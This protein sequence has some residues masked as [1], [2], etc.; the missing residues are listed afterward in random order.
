VLTN[1]LKCNAR[2]SSAYAGF[3]VV[4]VVVIGHSNGD[5]KDYLA[6]LLLTA[7]VSPSFLAS[8][9]ARVGWTMS[10]AMVSRMM[11]KQDSAKRGE[12]GEVL[13][14]GVL[15]EHQGYIM[16]VSKLRGKVTGGQS[17]P[18]TD[19][20]AFR[21]DEHMVVTEVCYVE[22]KLRTGR[23]DAT[24][25]E[26]Y[27]QL[28]ADYESAL[29]DIVIYVASRLEAE[30]SEYYGPVMDYFQDRQ[31]TTDRDTFCISLCWE[32]S[33]WTERILRN[34]EDNGIDLPRLSVHVIRLP[35]LR[36][37]TDEVFGALGIPRVEDDS[38]DEVNLN[39]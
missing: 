33:K 16:P 38:G 13:I 34:L 5:F 9:E 11:P 1:W 6:N 32:A 39:E 26:A 28:R 15:C 37:L 20:L 7:R 4:D 17:L 22:S 31:D 36:Q 23:N 10:R 2:D 21:L 14:N 30:G 8:V 35:R 29:P 19:S 27:E 25:V 24:A 18:G 3:K 12:F